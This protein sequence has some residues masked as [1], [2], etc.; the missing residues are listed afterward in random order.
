[1]RCSGNMKEAVSSAGVDEIVQRTETHESILNIV[2]ENPVN[3]S[4]VIGP[5]TEFAKSYSVFFRD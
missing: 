3:D 5:L 4:P 2:I 1:M